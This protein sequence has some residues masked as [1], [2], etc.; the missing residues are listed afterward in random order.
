LTSPR[1]RQQA[2]QDGIVTLTL[3][4]LLLI[5]LLALIAASASLIWQSRMPDLKRLYA[6]GVERETSGVDSPPAH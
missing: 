5:G 3:R 4:R 1:T 2:T 6:S